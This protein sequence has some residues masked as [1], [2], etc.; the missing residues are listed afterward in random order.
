MLKV[1]RTE[2]DDSFCFITD[3]YTVKKVTDFPVPSRDV[4]KLSLARNNL[5]GLVSDIP[6]GEGKSLTFFTVYSIAVDFF[7]YAYSDV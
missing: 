7:L 3:D 1:K 4:T 5:I 6:A 2:I